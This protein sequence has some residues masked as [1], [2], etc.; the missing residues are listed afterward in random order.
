M[1]HCDE[2]STRSPQCDRRRGRAVRARW[3]AWRGATKARRGVPSV[4]GDVVEWRELGDDFDEERW[5]LGEESLVWPKTWSSDESSVRSPQRGQRCDWVTRAWRGVPSV[6]G[7]MVE[8]RELDDK[9]NE[10]RWELNKES[11]AW[12]ETWLSD[13]SSAM[14]LT[15]SEESLVRSPQCGR[16]RG[17]AVR[18]QWRAWRGATRAWRAWRGA[19]RARR[20]VP[21]MAGDVVERREL[22]DDPNKERWE[23]GEESPAWPETWSSDASLSTILTRSDESLV[24][25]PQRG[26]RHGRAVRARRRAWRGAMKAQRGVPSV[27]EDVVEQ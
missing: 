6:T 25:S 24:R 15:R 2:S 14:I 13:E 5:E 22:V 19:M 18:A 1:R 4:A 8:R 12:L 21:S 26:W 20:G 17:R 9:L 7:D 23:L 10:E 27:A 3:Q 11:P 16:R